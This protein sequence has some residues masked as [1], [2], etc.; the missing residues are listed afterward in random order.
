[1][2]MLRILLFAALALP[3]SSGLMAQSEGGLQ[4]TLYLTDKPEKLFA[5][6]ETASPGVTLSSTQIARQGELIAGVIVF[7]D[8]APTEKGF[9]DVTVTYTL[10]KP[11]GAL[12]DEPMESETWIGKPP[13]PSNHLQLGVGS[14]CVVIEPEDP[15]G[16]YRMQAEVRDR[17]SGK[18]LRLERHFDAVE[19]PG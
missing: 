1:M 10:F 15:L 17:V 6:W 2:R 4:A 19:P 18:T 9:C 12:Y 3:C 5:D 16:R 7:A 14:F 13:P 8:C 11:D